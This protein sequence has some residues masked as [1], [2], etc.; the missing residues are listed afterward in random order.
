MK[1]FKV[2]LEFEIQKGFGGGFR[3]EWVSSESGA[4]LG[5]PY[6]TFWIEDKKTNKRIYYNTKVEQ[7]IYQALENLG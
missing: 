4:G 1:N 6:L 5:N 3:T 2:N 7:I